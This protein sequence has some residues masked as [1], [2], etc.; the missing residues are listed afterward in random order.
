[1]NTLEIELQNIQSRYRVLGIFKYSSLLDPDGEKNLYDWL[2]THRK[3]RYDQDERLVFIQDC[4]DTYEYTNDQ[5]NFTGIICNALQTVDISGSFVV[6]LTTN[7]NIATELTSVNRSDDMI[8]TVLIQG[9]YNPIYPTFG[10]TFCP[11]P[12]MHLHI[13]PAGNVLPCCCGDPDTPLGNINDDSLAD[14]YNNSKFQNLRK[15]LLS[16]KHPKE[17]K[18]CWVKESSGLRSQRQVNAE[19]YSVADP[20]PNGLVEFKPTTFDL[21]INKLCNLKCRSCSPELS[22]SIAQEVQAIYGVEWPALN[23][24]QRKSIL[25]ELLALLPNAEHVY[26]TGG[27]PL[28]APEHFA[29]INELIR[30]KHT[31]LSIF[32][33]TNFMQLDFRGVDLT[34]LWSQFSQIGIG[35]SLDAIGPVAEYLRHGTVWSTIESNLTR[36]QTTAPN[37]KFKVSST[38]GF[39]NVES[40]IDLQQ[41]WTQRGLLNIDQFF[42]PQIIIDSF[43]S[44]QVAPLHHKKRLDSIIC[45]HVDWLNSMHAFSLG[46]RWLEIKKHMW[47]EDRSH[48]LNEFRRTMS[49]QDKYRHESFEKVLPQFADL[50]GGQSC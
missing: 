3:D 26:F 34:T 49:N 2:Y 25:Q 9:E 6:L 24:S 27:E 4:A 41:N 44:I 36:L 38:V 40:L 32:Y 5:G 46:Q 50:M 10:D 1:M 35:A 21:R 14:I 15:S 23:N 20:N 13:N 37:V 30:L 48:L 17:C 22:S 7:K 45:N 18:D 33:N 28:L 43:F 47:Q 8:T 19:T 11:L 31:N 16:G 39:L 29:M 12:W 42:I